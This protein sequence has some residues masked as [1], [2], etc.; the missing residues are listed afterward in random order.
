MTTTRLTAQHGTFISERWPST[1]YYGK[2]SVWSVS[3]QSGARAWTLLWFA[4]PFPAGG[5]NV[6]RATL[7]LRLRGNN[8]RSHAVTAQLAGKWSNSFW[9]L[10]WNGRPSGV[11][12]RTDSTLT[13]LIRDGQV[14]DFDVTAQMQ[15]VADGGPFYGLLLWGPNNNGDA[16]GVDGR[17]GRVPTLTVDWSEAPLPPSELEPSGNAIVGTPTPML[18]WGFFDHVGVTDMGAYQVQ[19]ATSEGGFGSPSWDSGEVEST[20]CQAGLSE[21]GF[22]PPQPG[23]QV[24]WRVRNRDASGVWSGWSD[25]ARWRWMALPQV[26]LLNPNATGWDSSAPTVEVPTVTDP[27]PP[28]DW[29]VSGGDGGKPNRWQVTISRWRDGRWVVVADSGMVVSDQTRWTPTVAL[30]R[31]G[32]HQVQVRVWD[33]QPSRRDVPGVP[34]YGL[35]FA[36]FEYRPTSKVVPPAGLGVDTSA[37]TPR[38]VLS[39]TRDEQP[40]EWIVLRDGQLLSRRP[41]SD[42][43]T[44][45]GSYTI[46]DTLCPN[47]HHEWSVQAVVNGKASEPVTVSA[48]ESHQGT[49]LVDP[50]DHRMVCIVGDTDH[51]MTMPE[52]TTVLEPLGS[53]RTIVVTSGVRGWEGTVS[54]HIATMSGWSMQAAGQRAA[55][56]DW[57][58]LPGHTFRLLIEDMSLPVSIWNVQV[59][60]SPG[61]TGSRFADDRGEVLSVSLSFH[62]V[63]EFPFEV[64]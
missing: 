38:A 32:T 21:T 10:T 3:G 4:N 49:W 11:G 30:D 40:D 54:G 46:P 7:S 27:T 18:R 52:K 9:S 58:T 55:L 62:Q 43:V 34:I 60:Q 14:W 15:R 44:E 19:T 22:T 1:A 13:G 29:S 63:D 53:P 2:R 37:P 56:L 33:R 59:H 45:P 23:E 28:I 12:P 61:R 25:P 17:P 16:L 50:D 26:T 42:L 47:G 36:N 8:N 6:A 64:R 24:W 31:A 48:V 41:G 20:I 57:K 35:A 5:A 39:W 51:E